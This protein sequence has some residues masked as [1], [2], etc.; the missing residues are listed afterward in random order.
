M[1]DEIKYI[2][3]YKSQYHR[4]S[5]ELAAKRELRTS[6]GIVSDAHQQD[7]GPLEES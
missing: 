1:R 3:Y 2:F 4:C 6:E 5:R 7:I